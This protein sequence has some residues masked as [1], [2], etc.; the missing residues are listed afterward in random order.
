MLEW[1]ILS[2]IGMNL[3]ESRVNKLVDV[4]KGY[5]WNKNSFL[6]ASALK[7]QWVAVYNDT[8]STIGEETSPPIIK[9]RRKA[10]RRK[11]A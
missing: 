1:S 6:W 5:S 9:C 3:T 4:E 10:T 11:F 2:T 8:N 7:G